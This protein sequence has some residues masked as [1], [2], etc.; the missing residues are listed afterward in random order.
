[1][2]PQAQF[3]DFARLELRVGRI[4]QVEEAR[5][6]KPTFRLH[7]DFGPETGVKVSC[8]AV[9]NYPRETLVG[10]HVIGVVNFAPRQMGPEKSE[11]LLLGVPGPQ[12]ET[13][14]L[15]PQSAVPLGGEVF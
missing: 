12:G 11:V 14:L 13:I 8:A 1:M 5:T 9:R 7:V 3:D 10:M 4:T 15:T 2:K 6:K